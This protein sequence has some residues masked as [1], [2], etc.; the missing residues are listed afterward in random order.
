[1]NYF[2]FDKSQLMT[3]SWQSPVTNRLLIDAR[4]ATHGEELYNSVWNDDPN[5]VWRSLIA[6]TEQGG[7]YP[8]LLYRGAGQAAGPTF[9]F[10]AMSAPNIWEIRGSVTYVTGSHALKFGI[11][12]TWGRQY[13]LERDIHSSTS[14]RFNNGVPNQ[15]TM[16]A[17]PVNRYDD[18]KAEMGLYVQDKWTMNRLTLS[19][20]LRFDYFNTYFPETPLGPGPLVPNRNFTVAQYRLVQLEGPVA[21]RRG[22]LRPVRQRQDGGPG[23]HGPLR[24]G[25]RQHGRQRLFDPGQHRDAV[26]ERPGRPGDQRRLRAR[27]ATC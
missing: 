10:A 5:S 24:A 15:I 17:S 18:L 4:L 3:V 12:D 23:Q 16:R 25:R 8:G 2:K 6:V 19:A 13:L 27:N 22:G 7:A 14:Y 21:P 26:L 1:M 20:G 11:G 9:I